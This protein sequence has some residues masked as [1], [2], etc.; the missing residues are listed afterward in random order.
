MNIFFEGNAYSSEQ[1]HFVHAL[2]IPQSGDFN[3][4]N[5][6]KKTPVILLKSP[7]TS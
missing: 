6:Y 3:T 2:Q 5:A 4:E 7:V 1:V